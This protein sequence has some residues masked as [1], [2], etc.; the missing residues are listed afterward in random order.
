MENAEF[1]EEEISSSQNQQ[2]KMLAGTFWMTAGDFLSKILG[3]VYIIPWYAWMGSH[4]DQA[5]ALFSM[6]YNVYALFLLISTAGIPVAISREVAKYNAL[7]DR[8]MSY[9]LVRQMLVFMVILGAVFAGVM[10]LLAPFFAALSGGGKDL[11]PVMKSLSLAVLVFPAMSVIRGYFQGLSNMK[12][13]AL[14]QLFEQIV[15]VIWMLVTAFMIMKLGSGDW[16]A[17][18]TQ[19]TTAAFIGMIASSVV[20]ILALMKQGDIANITNPGPSKHQINAVNLLTQTLTQAIPFIVIGSAI[21]IFKLI[22]Q[23]TFPHVMR[24][25]AN[26]TDAQLAIF[27][28]YFSANTD[29]LTMVLIGVA[30]TLG[31]VGIPVITSSYVKGDKKETAHVISY[32]LQLFAVF[33]LPAVVGMS[34]LARE[35][36]TIFYVSPSQ[37][38]LNLFVFAFLQSFLL[39]SYALLSPMLQALRHSRV[40]MRY[41]ALTLVIKLVLQVPA[42]LLYE[43]YGPMIA[44]TIAF[45]IGVYLFLRK[46]QQ[47]SEFS[48]KVTFRGFLG[49]ATMTLIM[50]IIVSLAKWLLPNHVLLKTVVA[51][52]FGFAAYLVMAAKLGYLEK[53]FGAKGTSLRRKLHI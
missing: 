52:G 36:Y 17:A 10:Y 31:G 2:N 4:G 49:I 19:S 27:F 7:G 34:I 47:V 50:A 38:Q 29:K 24:M 5:N 26:Y 11:I 48:I 22:D 14:S 25:V 20:L 33:M 23:T 46:V 37:L 39:A 44:T 15:R 1:I 6:G 21:Q 9:R 45:G 41:F 8:N 12:P 40:A 53:L 28:S 18:V 13:Y 30:T 35:I 16:V 51:G 32:N 3:A 42:I 43:A